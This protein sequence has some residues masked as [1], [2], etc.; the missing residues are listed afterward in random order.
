MKISG[1]LNSTGRFIK[2]HNVAFLCAGGAII[3]APFALAAA[4]VI[5]TTLGAAGA[6]GTTAT[7]GTVIATLKGAI[8]TKASLAAIGNGALIAGGGGMTGGT[9]VITTAGAAVGATA[10]AA[11]RKGSKSIYNA[12]KKESI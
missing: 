2:K 12:I 9:A 4:P 1:V 10:S 5:A 3:A 6:L 7:T 11:I 8:L